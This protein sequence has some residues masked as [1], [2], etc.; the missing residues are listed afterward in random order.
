MTYHLCSCL[1]HH[2]RHTRMTPRMAHVRRSPP[3]PSGDDISISVSR[4]RMS[5][6]GTKRMI[7][8]ISPSC[9]PAARHRVPVRIF[10]RR[11]LE[12]T[13]H[14]SSSCSTSLTWTK[15]LNFD[16]IARPLNYST[17]DRVG[18][19]SGDPITKIGKIVHAKIVNRGRLL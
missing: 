14:A 13:F 6:S 16:V 4:E 10:P 8:R 19:T 9:L 7:P 3:A 1:T 17:C 5:L 11:S 18:T 15:S 12:S 2:V